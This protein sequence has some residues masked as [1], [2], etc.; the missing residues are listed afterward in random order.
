MPDAGL[1]LLADGGNDGAVGAA[2]DDGL[3]AEGFHMLDHGGE[4]LFG[5]GAFHD[6]D[7]GRGPEG[8]WWCVGEW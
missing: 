1:P 3:H 2:E 5:G 6:D 7:H 4:V 8:G